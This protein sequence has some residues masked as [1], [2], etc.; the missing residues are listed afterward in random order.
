MR[1]G[2]P[3][4]DISTAEAVGKTLLAAKSIVRR[5]DRAASA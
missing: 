1:A 2:L 3:R 4:R 5:R